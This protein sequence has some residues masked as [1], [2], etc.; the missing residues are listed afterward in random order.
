[1]EWLSLKTHK[2]LTGSDLFIR[3][4]KKVD[5]EYRYERYLV[6]YLVASIECFEN[7]MDSVLNWELSNNAQIDIALEDYVVTHFAVIDAVTYP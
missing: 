2:P 7:D 1:M 3:I 6:A 4:E 5:R